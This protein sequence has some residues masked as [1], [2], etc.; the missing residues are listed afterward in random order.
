ML[1]SGS[2]PYAIVLISL[3]PFILFLIENILQH[4]IAFLSQHAHL[5]V[6][7]GN[8]MIQFHQFFNLPLRKSGT[9]CCLSRWSISV[10]PQYMK[11]NF[12]QLIPDLTLKIDLSAIYKSPFIWWTLYTSIWSFSEIHE[13]NQGQD[14]LKYYP[15]KKHPRAH[16]T[17]YMT[18]GFVGS[19]YHW[20]CTGPCK[21]CHWDILKNYSSFNH[22]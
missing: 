4:I 18:S 15:R 7:W 13:K 1:Q 5:L 17:K 16:W 14:I 11:Y 22:H 9:Y 3:L 19:E 6:I 20:Q 10:G 2:I 8:F 21:G 12:Y